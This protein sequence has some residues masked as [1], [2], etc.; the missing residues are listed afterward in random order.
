MKT[1]LI[2]CLFSSLLV[3]CKQDVEP[4]QPYF[5]MVIDG[6][7][8]TCDK[9]IR[10]SSP[11]IG[12]TVTLYGRWAAGELTIELLYSNKIGEKTV[13]AIASDYRFDG[14]RFIMYDA[15]SIYC[16]GDE[17][18]YGG[19]KGSGKINILEISDEYVKGTFEF[20]APGLNPPIKKT[21]ING[22]FYIKRNP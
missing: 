15:E 10:G 6:R 13:K 22:E 1:L 11:K 4:F 21:V 8:V 5:R 7:L 14:P 12:N 9:E 17:G 18:V 20:V 3:S 16:A 19:V 2:V